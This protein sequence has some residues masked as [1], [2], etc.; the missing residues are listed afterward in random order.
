MYVESRVSPALRVG[1]EVWSPAALPEA[2]IGTRLR[3]SYSKMCSYY[4]PGTIILK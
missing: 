4:V 3:K 2:N 1:G